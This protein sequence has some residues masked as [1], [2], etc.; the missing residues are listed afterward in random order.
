M[1]ILKKIKNLAGSFHSEVVAIRRHLHAHPELSLQE[2]KTAAYIAEQLTAM[3]IEFQSGVAGTGLVANIYGGRDREKVVALR[4]D[5]DA[6]PISQENQ[7][8]YKSVYPGVMHACGHDVHMACLLGA[9]KI[10]NSI[11]DELPGSIRLLFQPSEETYQGGA[12]QM[13][14]E[15]ALENPRPVAVFGQHVY[16]QLEAGKVGVRGGMYMAS[17]D[18]IYLKVKGKGG[19]AATP[20]LVIDPILIASHIIVAL[21]Q[22]VSR[23]AKPYVPTVLSFG[24]IIGEGRTNVIP[25]V[26]SIDGT[27]RTFDEAW[28][29]EA[30]HL[31]SEIASTTA[32]AMGGECE[33]VFEKG[34]PFLVNDENLAAKFWQWAGE[35]VGEENVCSIDM[36]MGAEDFAYF[37]QVAPAC[38]YRLGTRNEEKGITSNIHTTTFDVDEEAL[39]TGMG[40]MAYL[41]VKQLET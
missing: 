41:A 14:E 5:M 27:F 2:H 20:H 10:L 12:S 25:D 37:S 11:K 28:R 33:V 29:A 3:G 17:T 6:L 19:H 24:K 7:V 39:E 16:P 30:H 22:V 32:K 38:F 23:R 15:G 4:A 26:V 34:Y 18:E 35:Y 40:L 13:I 21:Q 36:T 9:A 8:P 31:I 1:E